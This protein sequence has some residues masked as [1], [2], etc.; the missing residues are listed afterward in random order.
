MTFSQATI[1]AAS[2]VS[3]GSRHFSALIFPEKIHP[4]TSP[5]LVV[6]SFMSASAYGRG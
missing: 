6:F 2:H 1:H 4:T 3:E 5:T